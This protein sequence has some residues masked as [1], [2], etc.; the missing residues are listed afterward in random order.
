MSKYKIIKDFQLTTSDKKIVTLKAKLYINDFKYE[1]KDITITLDPEVVEQNPEYFQ[2][3]DW[4]ADFINH[5]KINKIPQPS[6]IAKKIL[7]YIEDN[8]RTEAGEKVIYIDKVIE[9]E[10]IVEKP[11][12]KI[13]NVEKVSIQADEEVVKELIDVKKEL[14]R[15]NGLLDESSKKSNNDN[16]ISAKLEKEM[17]NKFE[18]INIKLVELNEKESMLRQESINNAEMSIKNNELKIELDNLSKKL[19]DSERLLN[20]KNDQLIVKENDLNA[21]ERQIQAMDVNHIVE[22]AILDYEKTIPW[23]FHKKRY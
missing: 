18:N 16:A 12:E 3:I 9:V 1:S 6:I 14:K 8:F 4:K 21:K 17:L 19:A 10:K 15:V 20:E 23:Q 22:Q 11:V 2:F 13:V 5:L 7:P